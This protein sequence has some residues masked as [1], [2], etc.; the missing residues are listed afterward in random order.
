MRCC[1]NEWSRMYRSQLWWLVEQVCC[2]RSSLPWHSNWQ[3]KR[4]TPSP[5]PECF[6]RCLASISTSFP[7]LRGWILACLRPRIAF[8]GSSWG[9]WNWGCSSCS[10]CRLVT[11]AHHQA[12]LPTPSSYPLPP[13]SYQGYSSFLWPWDCSSSLPCYSYWANLHLEKTMELQWCLGWLTHWFQKQ[14]LVA[15]VFAVARSRIKDFTSPCWD[16]SLASLA[17]YCQSWRQI[18]HR[19]FPCPFAT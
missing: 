8:R 10:A 15:A 6:S 17:T 13:S 1:R 14:C 9:C 2:W 18:V 16:S 11:K 7:S 4:A 12:H 19:S 3:L 5:E